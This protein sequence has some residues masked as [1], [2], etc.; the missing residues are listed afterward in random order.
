MRFVFLMI[1]LATASCATTKT[2][3][4]NQVFETQNAAG[5]TRSIPEL[6]QIFATRLRWSDGRQSEGGTAIVVTSSTGARFAI[7]RAIRV[8]EIQSDLQSVDLH[9]LGKSVVPISLTESW[10]HPGAGPIQEPFLDLSDDVL[11]MPFEGPSEGASDLRVSNDGVAWLGRRVWLPL[12]DVSGQLRRVEGTVTERPFGSTIVE[13]DEQLQA[14]NVGS[15]V[16]AVGDQELV[17]IVRH[18]SQS[19]KGTQLLLTPA[20]AVWQRVTSD[21]LRYPLNT[22]VTAPQP[23]DLNHFWYGWRS[24]TSRRVRVR[25]TRELE[26]TLSWARGT[27]VQSVA[28]APSSGLQIQA[29]EGI[30]EEASPSEAN[31]HW[32]NAWAAAKPVA[33]SV[34]GQLADAKG[35]QQPTALDSSSTPAT[36][37]LEIVSSPAWQWRG[38]VELL[39]SLDFNAYGAQLELPKARDIKGEDELLHVRVAQRVACYPDSATRQC[40]RIILYLRKRSGKAAATSERAPATL[41]DSLLSGMPNGVLMREVIVTNV[42]SLLPVSVRSE[43]FLRKGKGELELLHT[44]LEERYEAAP[45]TCAADGENLEAPVVSEAPPGSDGRK[46]QQVVPD[47]HRNNTPEYPLDA[48]RAGLESLT[49]ARITIGST[50]QVENVCVFG[51]NEAFDESV[52]RAASTWRY[53]PA[54]LDGEPVEVKRVVLIP[55]MMH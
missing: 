12:Y 54:R 13:V 40:V 14:V 30:V 28:G 38:H 52:T 29:R 8:G 16:I 34:S 11:V 2:D 37:E 36:D 20:G 41:G 43:A 21:E 1:A 24:G 5:V 48:R 6:P 19:A 17:G 23:S 42:T 55:F 44:M 3:K 50:G 4:L 18:A 31:E 51:G 22:V 49:K 32:T 53:E 45:Y 39:T 25:R 7:M 15:P 27:W 26:G 9:G 10:G 46:Y 47:V 33:V 35:L